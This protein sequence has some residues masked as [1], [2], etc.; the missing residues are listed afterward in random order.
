MSSLVGAKTRDGDET[1]EINAGSDSGDISI[2]GNSVETLENNATA[3]AGNDYSGNN[4]P[5]IKRP[6]A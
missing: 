5:P 2:F 3:N 4:M 6:F 1:P